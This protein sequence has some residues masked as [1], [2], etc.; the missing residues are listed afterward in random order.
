MNRFA[1]QSTQTSQAALWRALSGKEHQIICLGQT[2]RTHKLY[3][4]AEANHIPQLTGTY[5]A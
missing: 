2:V 4:K 1:K 3:C 5:K